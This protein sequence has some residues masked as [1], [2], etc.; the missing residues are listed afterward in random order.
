MPEVDLH[1]FDGNYYW[2]DGKQPWIKNHRE[3]EA[4]DGAE[5]KKVAISDAK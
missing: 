5:G 1:P 2:M 3:T 4:N